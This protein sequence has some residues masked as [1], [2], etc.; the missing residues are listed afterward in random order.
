MNHSVE[1]NKIIK[2]YLSKN[3]Y[4]K[5]IRYFEFKKYVT[6]FEQSIIS[7][8]VEIETGKSF[9]AIM[10]FND[11]NQFVYCKAIS[12]YTIHY[13]TVYDGWTL[14]YYSDYENDINIHNPRYNKVEKIFS[15]NTNIGILIF[16]VI[17]F[18]FI[19]AIVYFFKTDYRLFIL[20]LFI[21]YFLILYLI[22]GKK[23][24]I[25]KLEKKRDE[26][27]EAYYKGRYDSD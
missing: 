1:L 20:S 15:S 25:S 11:Q 10:V 6:F 22:D 8:D 27:L 21:Y 13:I 9:A 23:R 7:G 19:C 4:V 16:F 18:L 26:F 3:I 5:E 24:Y 2:E 12:P 17:P 14:Y